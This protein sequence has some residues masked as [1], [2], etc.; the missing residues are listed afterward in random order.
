M[1]LALL[2]HPTWVI[3]A[4]DGSDLSRTAIAGGRLLADQ[5]GVPLRVVHAI[6]GKEAIHS[7]LLDEARHQADAHGAAF[8][9]IESDEYILWDVT[10][11]LVNYFAQWPG[12]LPVLT[13]HGR[14][15]IAKT[16][17]GSV[18]AGIVDTLATPVLVF[19][20][21]ATTPTRYGRILAC[22]DGSGFARA[23]VGAAAGLSRDLAVP[24]WIIDVVV[25][26]VGDT[27]AVAA[28]AH[29]LAPSGVSAEWDTLHGRNAA[30][31]LVDYADTEPGTISVLATH[32][33]TGW[34]N[35][36]MGSVAADVIRHATGPVLLLG[37]P[38]KSRP[39]ATAEA[40]G[41]NEHQVGPASNI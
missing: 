30:R 21:K 12:A 10:E 24:L 39:G 15:G 13:S 34:R 17:L 33:R 4:T 20:P 2:P 11:P 6:A 19:G 37:T 25:P 29:E 16:V 18:A 32:G 8:D 38:T 5:L 14:S 35:I 28:L 3:A 23:A 40:Q 9:V 22:T 31:S 36:V 26:D 27:P 41:R 1:T 7:A